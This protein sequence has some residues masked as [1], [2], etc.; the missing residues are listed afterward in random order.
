MICQAIYEEGAY[1]VEGDYALAEID[2]DRVHSDY[3]E[4]E[5]PLATAPDIYYKIEQG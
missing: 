3:D 2:G 5:R 1:F 4:E